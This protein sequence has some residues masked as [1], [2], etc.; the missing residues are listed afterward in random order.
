M[1]VLE[2][3]RLTS[4][5]FDADETQQ[6][7]MAAGNRLAAEASLQVKRLAF[8]DAVVAYLSGELLGVART[9]LAGAGWS[10]GQRA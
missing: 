6:L 1:N 9:E 2:F 8:P 7:N 4:Q 10:L 3:L 5:E